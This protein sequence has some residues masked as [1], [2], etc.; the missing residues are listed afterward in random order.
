MITIYE[1]DGKTITSDYNDSYTRIF[2]SL[3]TLPHPNP[4]LAIRFQYGR[5]PR[6]AGIRKLLPLF[7]KS[8]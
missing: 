8:R 4:A 5:L 2:D 7:Y 3:W 1:V 6:P